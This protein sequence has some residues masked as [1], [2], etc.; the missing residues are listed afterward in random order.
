VIGQDGLPVDSDG[1]GVLLGYSPT[2]PRRLDVDRRHLW[3]I[4][5]QPVGEGIGLGDW[6][7]QALGTYRF[8]VHGTLRRR[9][10]DD[11][12]SYRVEMPTFQIEPTS[13]IVNDETAFYAASPNGYRARGGAE[14]P[15]EAAPLPKDMV[16]SLTCR[17][18][19]QLTFERQVVVGE[20]G[21]VDIQ[22]PD[23]GS[24]CSLVDPYGNGGLL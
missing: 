18:G 21:S 8:I 14:T 24:A 17:L 23:D 6:A 5:W 9:A 2:P 16:L 15:Q 1:P 22:R 20:N 4:V 7:A 12:E 13:I 3:T 19:D 11:P 10:N